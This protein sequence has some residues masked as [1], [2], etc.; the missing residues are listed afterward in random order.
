MLGACWSEPLLP[1]LSTNHK[2][3]RQQRFV[4]KFVRSSFR[5]AVLVSVSKNTSE[6]VVMAEFPQPIETQPNE[7]RN[8]LLL[9]LVDP[10]THSLHRHYSRQQ[11]RRGGSGQRWRG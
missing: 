3:Q 1:V 2:E 4:G 7:T 11:Q 8:H 10:L 6:S 9:E 5:Q